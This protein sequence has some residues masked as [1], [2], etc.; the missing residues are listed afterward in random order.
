LV[1]LASLCEISISDMSKTDDL[2]G[3]FEIAEI[4]Q[5]AGLA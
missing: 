4:K 2:I 3:Q 5:Q 1:R